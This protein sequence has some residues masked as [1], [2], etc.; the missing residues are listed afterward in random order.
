MPEDILETNE[1]EF[2][3]LETEE[4]VE[5]EIA[6]LMLDNDMDQETAEKVQEIIDETGLDEDD[7]LELV[8]Y[9]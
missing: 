7:A 4:L 5:P 8:E 6:Q 2:I 1:E 9:L 3:N